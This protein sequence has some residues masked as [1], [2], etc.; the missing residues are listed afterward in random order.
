MNNNM[1]DLKITID[2]VMHQYTKVS[3]EERAC[4]NCSLRE[5]CVSRYAKKHL[6]NLF[7]LSGKCRPTGVY[8]NFQIINEYE[9]T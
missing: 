6:C 1:N 5:Y 4:A 3:F 9:V 2:G 7:D 8:G